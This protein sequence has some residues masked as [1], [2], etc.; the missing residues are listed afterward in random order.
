MRRTVKRMSGWAVMAVL[1]FGLWACGE[2]DPNGNGNGITLDPDAG[3]DADP[4][5]DVG[6]VGSDAEVDDV[7]VPDPED[8]EPYDP[9]PSCVGGG[10]GTLSDGNQQEYETRFWDLSDTPFTSGCSFD[11]TG[12]YDVMSFRGGD[13]GTLTVDVVNEAEVGFELRTVGS[14]PGNQPMGCFTGSFSASEILWDYRY[15]V[16]IHQLE[17]GEEAELEIRYDYEEQCEPEGARRCV[18]G[19][20]VELCTVTFLSPDTPRWREF[21]CPAGCEEDRCQ[22]DTC[23]NALVVEG[24]M[25]FGGQLG[26]MANGFDD[27][28]AGSCQGEGDG[29][30]PARDMVLLLSGLSAGQEVSIEL[31]GPPV[32]E[33]V[34]ILVQESCGASES[35]V[36][37]YEGELDV[38]FEAPAAGDY[39]VILDSRSVLAGVLEVSI[40][41]L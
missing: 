40:D 25:Q 9:G 41:F 7:E 11:G 24:P 21:S 32:A 18:D 36:A 16:V 10:L 3:G 1:V 37:A 14:C 30:L 2:D 33:N 29:A 19:D 35:C 5:P 12:N 6:D 8:T 26:G 31:D 17:A 13:L 22:G 27:A 23:D 39:Y 28:Q 15:Y 4:G 34:L 20:H 38:V